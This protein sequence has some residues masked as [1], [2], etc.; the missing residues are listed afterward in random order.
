LVEKTVLT[1]VSKL[2][3]GGHV[4]DNSVVVVGGE[5]DGSLRFSV[6]VEGEAN[7]TKTASTGRPLGKTTSR[8]SAA[9]TQNKD[10]SM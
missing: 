6:H 9:S 3:L 4:P 2:L 1:E 5:V 8:P 10:R 7:A